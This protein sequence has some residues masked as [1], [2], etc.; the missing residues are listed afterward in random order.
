MYEVATREMPDR[1]LYWS[2]PSDPGVDLAVP[3]AVEP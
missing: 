3:F 1:S 2:H